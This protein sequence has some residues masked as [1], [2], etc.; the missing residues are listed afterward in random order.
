MFNRRCDN[1]DGNGKVVD[2]KRA[3]TTQVAA[4]PSAETEKFTSPSSRTAARILMAHAQECQLLSSLPTQGQAK[5]M[6]TRLI[7]AETI[8]FGFGERQNL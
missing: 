7:P 6:S 2:K 8:S 1:D 5:I 4:R 3:G